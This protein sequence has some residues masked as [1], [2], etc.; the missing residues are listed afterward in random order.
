MALPN[1]FLL[2]APKA[3]TTS[4]AAALSMHPDISVPATK[5]P[6]FF[7]WDAEYRKGLAHFLREHYR[8]LETQVR[9]DA[10]VSYLA[11]PTAAQRIAQDLNPSHHRFIIVLRE[12]VERAY[13]NY[14]ESRSAGFERASFEEAVRVDAEREHTYWAGRYPQ[15]HLTASRYG[16]HL[17]RWLSVFPR[18]AFLILRFEEVKSDTQ[19][20][21]RRISEFVGVDPDLGSIDIPLMKHA[22]NPRWSA[23][24]LVSKSPESIKSAVRKIAGQRLINSAVG[25]LDKAT[26]ADRNIPPIDLEVR[27]RLREL[28]RPEVLLT[29][30]LTG[31]DLTDWR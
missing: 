25:A 11:S 5:E 1:L 23:V 4:L 20:T 3:A 28:L 24:S 9:L 19:Q 10:S 8:D 16:T 26:I 17:R 29:E 30:D 21:L 22:A 6:D 14:W 13:S 7:S 12:P 15:S 18:E 31:L 2:G 27:D